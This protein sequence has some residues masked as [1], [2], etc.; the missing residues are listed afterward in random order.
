MESRTRERLKKLLFI[1]AVIVGVAILALMIR[2][3]ELPEQT[4]PGETA[5]T[6]RVISLNETTVLPRAVGYG[7][8]QPGKVWEAVAQVSGNIIEKSARLQKGA[9][10]PAGEVLLRIDPTD[11]RLVIAQIDANIRGA[12]AQLE[13]LAVRES[14]TGLSMEIEARVLALANE[15]LARKRRL[16]ARGNISQSSVDQEERT[17]LGQE[18]QVQSLRNTLN[19][20]PAER[21][22]LQAQ[23]ELY[24]TQLEDAGLDLERTTIILPFDARVAGVSVERNQFVRVG[25]V[26]VEAD[27]IDVAEIA[28]QVPLDKM[29]PLMTPD[30][31]R[32]ALTTAEMARLTEIVPFTAV[33]RLRAG[34]LIVDWPARFARISDTIDPQTRTLGVIVAVDDPYRQARPGIRPPLVKNMFVEVEVRGQT[35][36]EILVVPRAALHDG[37]VYV[38]DQDNRLEIRAIEIG[39]VQADFAIVEAGLAVGEAI[40][41]S[42]L[43]PA[44]AGMRLEPVEDATAAEALRAAAAGEGGAR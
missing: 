21:D 7:L 8:V 41:I 24:R 26:L 25:E 39:L 38:V 34:D 13:E 33:V 29:R 36:P 23:L 42:D 9:I 10:L 4:P 12:E 32:G 15:E 31:Q 43:S 14:N 6:V 16:L 3:R 35:R 19:L 44:V 30:P 2:Q 40:V 11:Y 27:S 20:I 5:R 18:Q 37:R 28:A 17:V 1:P 22:V